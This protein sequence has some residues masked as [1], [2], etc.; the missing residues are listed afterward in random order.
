MKPLTSW[1]EGE[2]NYCFI[3]RMKIDYNIDKIYKITRTIDIIN[4][5]RR[6][7]EDLQICID[8][9][10]KTFRVCS[11]KMKKEIKKINLIKLILDI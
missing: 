6:L 8:F 3:C 5:Y 11:F 1:L 4:V 7:M 10:C 2:R 9:G